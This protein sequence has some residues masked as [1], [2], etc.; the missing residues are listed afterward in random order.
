MRAMLDM[1]KQTAKIDRWLEDYLAMMEANLGV[2]SQSTMEGLC[3]AVVDRILEVRSY[4][5]DC[6]E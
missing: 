3:Q 6:P 2:I 1:Q 4:L 5:K